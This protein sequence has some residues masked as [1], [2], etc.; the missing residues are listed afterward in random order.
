MIHLEMEIEIFLSSC[1]SY[2]EWAGH[3]AWQAVTSLTAG[4]GGLS[5]ARTVKTAWSMPVMKNININ[6]F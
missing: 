1:F 4:V 6:P 2:D 3:G 5:L